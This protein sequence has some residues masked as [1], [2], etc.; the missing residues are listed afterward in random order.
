MPAFCFHSIILEFILSE[1]EGSHYVHQ[2]VLWASFSAITLVT[3]F[4]AVNVLI[5]LTA[6]KEGAEV[7]QRKP[8]AQTLE[9]LFSA[10]DV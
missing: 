6:E 9:T 8:S 2:F 5:T 4:S 1:V 3:L 7:T 10:V